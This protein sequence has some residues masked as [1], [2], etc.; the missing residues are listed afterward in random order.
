MRLGERIEAW[1]VENPLRR[2]RRRES[3]SQLNVASV[4]GVSTKSIG[5]W[6][7]GAAIPSDDHFEALATATGRTV[8]GLRYAWAAWIKQRPSAAIE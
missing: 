1:A 2:W 7:N 5:L 4:I 8:S 6:E 3:L